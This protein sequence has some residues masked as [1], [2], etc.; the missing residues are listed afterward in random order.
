MKK[1]SIFNLLIIMVLS[2]SLTLTACSPKGEKLDDTIAQGEEIEND[3][4]EVE[5]E[6]DQENEI[7]E[8]EESEEIPDNEQKE[9]VEEDSRKAKKDTAQQEENPQ[10]K[11]KE[12]DKKEDAKDI[13][14]EETNILKV[15]GKVGKGLRLGLNELKTMDSLLF[16]GEFYSINN[17]GTTNHTEF[18]GVSLWKLLEE[19]EISGDAVSVEIIAIDGYKMEFTVEQVKRQDYMDETKKDAKFPMIIAWEEDG[20]EYDPE[21]GPPYKLIIGQNEP[22]DVNKP[23][24]VSKIDKIIVK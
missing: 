9:L 22:G 18:K 10:E 19:A 17:F 6:E 20:E 21:E 7:K 14:E 8:S 11:D 15:E 16:K 12:E 24:W 23:Q 2:I 5:V 4:V 1:F 13:P 3:N